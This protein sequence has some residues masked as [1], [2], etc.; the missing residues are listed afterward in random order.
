VRINRYLAQC[1]FGSRRNVEQLIEK[2]RVIVDGQL[3]VDMATKIEVGINLV[4]VDGVQAELQNDRCET[5]I[6]NKPPGYLCTR[7][8]P[9]MRKS[10]YALLEHLPPPYQAVGRLD[11]NSRGL[12]IIT[13]NGELSNIIMHPRYE[14]KKQYKVRA[15]GKWYPSFEKKLFDGV[16]MCEGGIGRMKVL[17][18]NQIS[19]TDTELTLELKEGKKRE[20]RYSLAALNLKVIDLLRTQIDFLNLNGLKEGKSRELTADELSKMQK[21][22]NKFKV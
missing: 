7:E 10:I 21:L 15:H 13:K 14:I 4:T 11:K 9:E 6:F 3:C 5:W 18:C 22:F 16:K 20:I 19:D 8:D 17:K 1:G 2:S 12:L